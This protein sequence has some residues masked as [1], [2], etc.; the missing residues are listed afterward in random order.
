MIPVRKHDRADVN[1][2]RFVLWPVYNHGSGKTPSILSTVVRVIPRSSVEIGLESVCH[3][4]SRRDWALLHRRNTV[5]PR[6]CTLKNP[7]PMKS[8]TF[9]WSG[10]LVVNRDLESITPIGFELGSRKLVVD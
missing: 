6:S 4:F 2:V 8:G 10:D 5:V 9:F 1:V 7:M 3:C